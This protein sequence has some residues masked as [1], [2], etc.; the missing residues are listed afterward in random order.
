MGG[1]VAHPKLLDQV[2]FVKV[3]LARSSIFPGSFFFFAS[4]VIS[5]VV[6]IGDVL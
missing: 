3:A 6:Q 2:L 5:N 1:G 4:L